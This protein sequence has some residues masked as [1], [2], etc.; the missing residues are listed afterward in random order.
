MTHRVAILGG[1]FGGLYAARALAARRLFASRLEITIF[2]RAPCFVFKPLLYELLTD[3]VSEA[4]I[5]WPFEDVLAGTGIA[6][7]RGAVA[8]LHPHPA[9]PH[10]RSG[11]QHR[12]VRVHRRPFV[13]VQ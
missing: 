1:G 10:G 12:F 4:E 2:D 3:E 9:R 7:E 6:H 11:A 13:V 5:S 8:V